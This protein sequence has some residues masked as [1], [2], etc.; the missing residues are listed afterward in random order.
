MFAARSVSLDLKQYEI[1][2]HD[3]HL[4]D[5]YCGPSITFQRDMKYFRS[6]VAIV[7]QR[8]QALPAER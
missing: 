1:R 5:E 3:D 6:R 7:I 8:H 4:V 2:V